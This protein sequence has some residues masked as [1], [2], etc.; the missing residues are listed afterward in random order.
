MSCSKHITYTPEPHHRKKKDKRAE[1][2]PSSNSTVIHFIY[3]VLY[4]N[5][6]AGGGIV[7][8]SKTACLVQPSY[9]VNTEME[10]QRDR[11]FCLMLT[12]FRSPSPMPTVL[13]ITLCD[14]RDDLHY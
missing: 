14:R 2:P 4:S 13:P 3:S 5:S 8:L 12:K 11:M 7:F 6:F 1:I 10:L 9:L